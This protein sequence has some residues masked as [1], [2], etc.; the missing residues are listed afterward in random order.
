MHVSRLVAV[1]MMY[2]V[3]SHPEQWAAL[4]R[5]HRSRNEHV[6][7]PLRAAK[8]PVAQKPVQAYCG[9]ESD[10][11]IVE[12]RQPEITRMHWQKERCGGN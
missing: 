11:K 6:L 9:A 12:N 4:S 7:Q 5:Q 10:E 1:L 2:A 3:I 8:R